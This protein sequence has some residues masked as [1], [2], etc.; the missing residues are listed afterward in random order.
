MSLLEIFY[1]TV[2]KCNERG[3]PRRCGGQGDLSSGTIGIFSH[4]AKNTTTEYICTQYNND[5]LFIV[6]VPVTVGSLVSY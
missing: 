3:S 2:I 1:F 6:P 5:T 4:W